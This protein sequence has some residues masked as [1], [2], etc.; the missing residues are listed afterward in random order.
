MR[1][2]EDPDAEVLA[3]GSV[4]IGSVVG[5]PVVVWGLPAARE[6]LDFAT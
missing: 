1:P 5:A 6:G 3:L 2:A 4:C